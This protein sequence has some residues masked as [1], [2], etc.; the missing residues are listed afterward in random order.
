MMRNR[1]FV[2]VI[3]FLVLSQLNAEK[4]PYQVLGV[5]RDTAQK[6]IQK[7][8]KSLCL[9]FHP[10]KNVHKPLKERRRC[11]DKFK[12][13][14]HAYS[15]IV[16]E[17]SRRMYDL[18]QAYAFRRPSTSGR[19]NNSWPSGEHTASDA[20]FR[21]FSNSGPSFFFATRPDGRP[22]FGIRRPFP[23]NP[24]EYG[25]HTNLSFKSIYKQTVKVPLEQLYTG[26]ELEFQLIDNVWTRWRAAI[27]GKI[28]YLSLYQGL[29]YSMPM[30][31]TSKILAVIV[32]LFISHATLPK[33]DPLQTYSS[34][35]PRGVKGNGTR[36]RFQQ[37]SNGQPEIIFEIQEAAHNRY[38]RVENDLHTHIR[39]TKREAEKGCTKEIPSLDPRQDPLT[40]DIPPHTVNGASVRIRGKGWP[41]RNSDIHGDLLVKVKIKEEGNSKQGKR[42]KNL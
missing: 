21:A 12:E 18:Q 20:F 26:A 30:I 2:L 19:S 15:Q 17:K 29:L 22:T 25:V 14:Q 6:E 31:R 9:K 4:S 16:D 40:I 10:D 39:I 28:I 32:G 5:T 1:G 23:S 34:T 24:A 42:R 13:I 38:T 27:R 41:T 36:I 3:L 11:E 7:S 37:N 33:P 8:Y 35:L